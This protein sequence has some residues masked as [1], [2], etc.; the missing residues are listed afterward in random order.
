MGQIATSAIISPLATIGKNV[1]IDDYTI[2]RDNVI[3]EDDVTIHSHCIIGERAATPGL[4]PLTIGRGALIRSHSIFYE[5]SRFGESL[6]TGHHVTIREQ[7]I[8]GKGLQIGS[9][10]D[11]QGQMKI[12]D[13]TRTQSNTTFATGTIIGSFVWIYPFTITTNDPHPPSNVSLVTHIDDFAVVATHCCLLPGLHIGK[14]SFTAA[15]SLVTKDVPDGMY[16]RGAPA[17]II[18]PVE[19]LKHQ[20]EQDKNAYPWTQHFHRGYPASIVDRWKDVPP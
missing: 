8:A 12:G 16:V 1:T 20:V 13:Y 7:T 3:L 18:G 9:Y 6:R 5:G 11:W 17:K 19:L 10:A 2:V 15:G 4:G 14:N